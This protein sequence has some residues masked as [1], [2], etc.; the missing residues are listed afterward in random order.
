MNLSDPE[1]PFYISEKEIL[2]ASHSEELETVKAEMRQNTDD[3]EFLLPQIRP[4]PQT[5]TETKAPKF[6]RPTKFRHL[7]GSYQP[8]IH[9]K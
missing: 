2:N 8:L 1:N 6:G 4:S 9:Y 7:K 3:N 5:S